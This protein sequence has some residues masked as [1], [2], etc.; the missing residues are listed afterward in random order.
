MPAV[1]LRHPSQAAQ[2]KQ[3]FRWVA[4]VTVLLPDLLPFLSSTQP[5][6]E[7]TCGRA[8]QLPLLGLRGSRPGLLGLGNERQ[9]LKP[10]LA[11]LL[12]SRACPSH[13]EVV[14]RAGRPPALPRPRPA[15][16]PKSGLREQGTHYPHQPLC[17][18]L[19]PSASGSLHQSTHKQPRL[20]PQGC[21]FQ[22]SSGPSSLSVGSGFSGFWP[23]C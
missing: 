16:P 8:T 18:P 22:A 4:V 13:R 17:S 7:A 10:A 11:P 19:T 5:L 9:G 23:P 1:T 6:P 21:S 20:W 2:P 15:R 14:R 12:G 3:V